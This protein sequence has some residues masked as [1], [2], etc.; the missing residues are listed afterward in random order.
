[1]DEILKCTQDISQVRNKEQ[2]LKQ[3]MK[4]NKE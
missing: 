3:E 4:S 2:Y 1:M